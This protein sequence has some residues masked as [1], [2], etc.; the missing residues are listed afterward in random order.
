MP[1]VQTRNCNL[2]PMVGFPEWGPVSDPWL[3]G[4]CS[5]FVLGS[6]NQLVGGA[7]MEGTPFMCPGLHPGSGSVSDVLVLDSKLVC[8]FACEF[9]DLCPPGGGGKGELIIV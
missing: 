5:R 9:P 8:G 1:G 2:M 3:L 7:H 4:T 6:P